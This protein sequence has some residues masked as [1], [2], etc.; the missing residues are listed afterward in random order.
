[1]MPTPNDHRQ[2]S[3]E[4]EPLL[5][6]SLEAD[7]KG[8][9]DQSQPVGETGLQRRR[10][11]VDTVTMVMRK[12][13][14]I[15]MLLVCVPFGLVAGILEWNPVFVSLMNFL[16]IIPLSAAISTASDTLAD[17]LGF[18]FG[19]LVNATFGNVVELSVR[20]P[21]SCCWPAPITD[22]GGPGRCSRHH[23]Q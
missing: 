17:E 15:Y 11:A 22:S 20:S 2:N 9:Q 6:G 7:Q 16:A 21:H 10:S 23:S 8:H 5:G 4:N 18:L 13:T 1:M 14:G 19:G 12:L 3:S